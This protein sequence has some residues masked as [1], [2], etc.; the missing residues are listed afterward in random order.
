MSYDNRNIVVNELIGLKA[1]VIKSLDR[2]QQGISGTVIDETK[3]TITL[4]TEKGIKK[5]MKKTS[6]FRFLAEG[7]AFTV[8]GDEINFRPHERTEKAMRFF[9]SRKV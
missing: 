4:E 6:V 8:P 2:K 1:K 5:I 3:N 7:K 9:K